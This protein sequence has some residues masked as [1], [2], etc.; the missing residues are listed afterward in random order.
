MGKRQR[1]LTGS[2]G[3][4]ER[5]GKGYKKSG[6]ETEAHKRRQ[7]PTVIFSYTQLQ[8]QNTLQSAPLQHPTLPL[9]LT[10]NNRHSTTTDH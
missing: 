3:Q 8:P 10:V 1:E 2:E 7:S 5:G 9:P 6:Q 4:G